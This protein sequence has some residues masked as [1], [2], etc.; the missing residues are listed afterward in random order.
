MHTPTDPMT[1]RLS[2]D[3]VTLIVLGVGL[4]SFG[5][6]C[7]I[8]M[9]RDRGIPGG[10]DETLGLLLVVGLL[11][12]W[13]CLATWVVDALRKSDPLRRGWMR[14]ICAGVVVLSWVLAVLDQARHAQRPLEELEIPAFLGYHL[15]GLAAIAVV[16]W[17]HRSGRSERSTRQQL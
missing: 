4:C 2:P 13:G 9:K 3:W 6:M 11:P 15:L 16:P 10:G 5:A 1:R 7:L 14:S 17:I 12:Y 8:E